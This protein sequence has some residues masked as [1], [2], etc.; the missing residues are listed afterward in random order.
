MIRYSEKNR[1]NYP[2]EKP[3]LNF[4]PGLALPGV[5]SNNWAV[6]STVSC[7]VNDRDSPGNGA[8]ENA[9]Y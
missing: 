7:N 3:E 8:R 1:E 4:N 5:R 6:D 9:F 2:R